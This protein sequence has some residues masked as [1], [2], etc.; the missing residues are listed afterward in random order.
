M[1]YTALSIEEAAKRSN[2]AQRNFEHRL[3]LVKLKKILS[4]VN[5]RPVLR[6]PHR[7]SVNEFATLYDEPAFQKQVEFLW[8]FL[9]LSQL[10]EVVNLIAEVNPVSLEYDF[11]IDAFVHVLLRSEIGAILVLKYLLAIDFWH[12]SIVF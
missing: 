10:R 1:V 2:E 4:S 9:Q 6:D 7:M 12:M 11:S 3:G 8:P 5:S